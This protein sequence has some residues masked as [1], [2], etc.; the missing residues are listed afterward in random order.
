MPD[1]VVLE[2]RAEPPYDA[3]QWRKAHVYEVGGQVAFTVGGIAAAGAIGYTAVCIGVNNVSWRNACVW[4]ARLAVGTT[5]LALGGGALAIYGSFGEAQAVRAPWT[6]GILGVGALSLSLPVLAFGGSFVMADRRGGVPLLLA[7]VGLIDLG[8]AATACQVRYGHQEAR[9][10][11]LMGRRSIRLRRDFVF[12]GMLDA[13]S[14]AVTP[15]G[16]TLSARW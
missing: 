8:V 5:G 9:R 7:G 1:E 3:E 16:A 12:C 14:L 10:L 13:F 15:T 11:G 6:E 4:P 2:E